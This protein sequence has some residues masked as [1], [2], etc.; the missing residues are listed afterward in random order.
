MGSE[1]KGQKAPPTRIRSQTIPFQTPQINTKSAPYRLLPHSLCTAFKGQDISSKPILASNCRS[2]ICCVLFPYLAAVRAARN[3][4]TTLPTL[5]RSRRSINQNKCPSRT[6][7]LPRHRYLHQT[8]VIVLLDNR[9]HNPRRNAL[10][11]PEVQ[12]LPMR[13]SGPN[14]GASRHHKITHAPHRYPRMGH[15]RHGLDC[16]RHALGVG[17]SQVASHHPPRCRA[18]AQ[19]ATMRPR[20]ILTAHAQPCMGSSLKCLQQL[21]TDKVQAIISCFGLQLLPDVRALEDLATLR[22]PGPDGALAPEYRTLRLPHLLGMVCALKAPQNR[23]VAYRPFDD[24]CLVFTLLSWLRHWILSFV[25][26]CCEEI[27]HARVMPLTADGGLARCVTGFSTAL[28]HFVTRD[29]ALIH[30]AQEI[31]RSALIP[32]VSIVVYIHP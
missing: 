23:S 3:P 5:H 4:S 22:A 18:P 6:A 16:V 9:T 26:L 2:E 19:F 31:P 30:D 17:K 27:A 1:S 20:Q 24:T 29:A 21:G 28:L 32:C 10:S 14:H 13:V 25:C 11:F 15:K 7:S 12:A 8:V